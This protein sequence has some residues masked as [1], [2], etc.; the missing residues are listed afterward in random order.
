V[1]QNEEPAADGEPRRVLRWRVDQLRRAGYPP[2][3]A[4]LLAERPEVDLHLAADLVRHGCP[5]ATAREIL[6]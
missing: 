5:V 4:E 1:A 2:G 3:D 6:L